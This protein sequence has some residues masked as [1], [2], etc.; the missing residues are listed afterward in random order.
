MKLFIKFTI[1]MYYL[2]LTKNY[3]PVRSKIFNRNIGNKDKI[4]YTLFKL[5][6]LAKFFEK[7][8]FELKNSLNLRTNLIL[9]T[10]CQVIKKKNI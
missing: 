8:N 1:I 7:I 9:L 6:Q 5:L 2:A 10:L 4:L 3:N